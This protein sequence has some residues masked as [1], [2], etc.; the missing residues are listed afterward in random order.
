MWKIVSGPGCAICTKFKSDVGRFEFGLPALLLSIHL[1]W[2]NN[3]G[4]F[5]KANAS[6]AWSADALTTAPSSDRRQY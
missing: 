4:L 2:E 5:T 3:K 6:G 1:L